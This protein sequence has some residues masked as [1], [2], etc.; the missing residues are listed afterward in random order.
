MALSKEQIQ[1]YAPD[2]NQ[3]VIPEDQAE[4]EK[5]VNGRKQ[6]PIRMLRNGAT[7]DEVAYNFTEDEIAISAQNYLN[8]LSRE[9]MEGAYDLVEDAVKKRMKADEIAREAEQQASAIY[10]VRDGWW[11]RTFTNDKIELYGAEKYAKKTGRNPSNIQQNIDYKDPEAVQA[12]YD[13][14]PKFEYRRRLSDLEA[15][16]RGSKWDVKNI[17]AAEYYERTGDFPEG[18][19]EDQMQRSIM[20]MAAMRASE[21]YQKAVEL[22]ASADRDITAAN[23]IS[24]EVVDMRDDIRIAME[25]DGGLL[26]FDKL[27]M[28][29]DATIASNPDITEVV[30]ENEEKQKKLH[31]AQ[32]RQTAIAAEKIAEETKTRVATGE[33]VAGDDIERTYTA[34]GEEIDL[35]KMLADSGLNLDDPAVKQNMAYMDNSNPA[36]QLLG[37]KELS[38]IAAHAG[39]PELQEALL[40]KAVEV[41]TQNPDANTVMYFQAARDLEI[42]TNGEYKSPFKEEPEGQK[43]ARQ[44]ANMG[45]GREAYNDAV[46][47]NNKIIDEKVKQLDEAIDI[48]DKAIQ[49]KGDKLDLTPG[50]KEYAQIC[51]KASSAIYMAK[52]LDLPDFDPSKGVIMNINGAYIHSRLIKGDDGVNRWQHDAISPDEIQNNING[53]AD[54]LAQTNALLADLRSE[55]T[56]NSVRSFLE[57]TPLAEN[58]TTPAAE[59]ALAMRQKLEALRR[60]T[61]SPEEFQKVTMN[62]A[63]PS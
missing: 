38:Q 61:L 48:E 18:V 1:E 15:N 49:E 40:R 11:G 47:E 14:E 55:R 59:Q 19:T 39:N 7:M 28:A 62:M 25:R 34:A 51:A 13:A 20:V 41:G 4:P 16:A 3:G 23:Q 8:K 12:A 37:L 42:V 53:A 57:K 36:V 30:L 35:Q 56:P 24:Q 10:A 9:R 60:D 43:A 31:E 26:W 5:Y 22:R 46:T 33:N 44:A 27:V 6:S 21:T 54:A 58:V 32:D 17:S 29:D 45:R 52:E 2:F 50:S 63:T